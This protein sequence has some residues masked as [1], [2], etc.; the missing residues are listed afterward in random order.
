M[1]LFWELALRSFQRQMT[2]RAATLAG[3]VTNFFFGILRASVLVAL[4]G[5]RQEM[6]GITVMGAVTYTGITQAV[7]GFLSLFGWYELMNTVYTGA[8]AADLLKPM[9]YY[10]FWM[11]Q[12]FGR[13][14]AQ[15]LLRGLPIIAGYALLYR[16]SMPQGLGQW[17]ALSLALILAWLVSFSWRFLAN[18]ASFWVPN[19]MGVIR[20]AFILWWLF[21]GFLMPLRFFPD[22]FVRL[23]YL[24]PFPYTINVVIEIYLGLL[25]GPA[26]VQALLAQLGWAIVLAGLGQVALRAGVRR[27]VI[28]G[29]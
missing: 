18:L 22:W 2:Y 1:R 27:L 20:F 28:L 14:M 7:I 17:L 13:A 16:I 26:L 23:C 4:Y 15:L 8:V 10:R 12:D 6:A 24:T 21:S 9:G 29:G 11:A 25:Q 3:L 5:A 19:A